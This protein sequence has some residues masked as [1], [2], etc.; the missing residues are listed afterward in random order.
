MIETHGR[1][2]ATPAVPPIVHLFRGLEDVL[3]PDWDAAGK[4][5]DTAPAFRYGFVLNPGP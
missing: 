1:D 2:A 3:S 5:G 4:P